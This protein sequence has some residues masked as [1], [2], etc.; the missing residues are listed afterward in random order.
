MAKGLCWDERCAA[1][2]SLAAGCLGA[3]GTVRDAGAALGQHA[4]LIVGVLGTGA[5][6]P[7]TCASLR[8]RAANRGDC[9]PDAHGPCTHGG[10][11]AHGCRL[12]RRARGVFGRYGLRT[13]RDLPRRHRPVH[14]WIQ[15]S[16]TS[17]AWTV[18]GARACRCKRASSSIRCVSDPQRRRVARGHTGVHAMPCQAEL[19]A[20]EERAHLLSWSLLQEIAFLHRQTSRAL[21]STLLKLARAQQSVATAQAQLWWAV[22]QDIGALDVP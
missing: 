9:L 17:K 1:A 22:E 12:Q 21:P 15:R 18:A 10:L 19:L 20:K 6:E 16:A 8:R 11:Q 4:H 5:T 7:N 14:G 2:T 13:R 3:G